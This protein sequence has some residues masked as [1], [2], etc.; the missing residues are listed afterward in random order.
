MWLNVCWFVQMHSENY[1]L[2]CTQMGTAETS[3]Q[4]YS[5]IVCILASVGFAFVAFIRAVPGLRPHGIIAATGFALTATDVI[6]GKHHATSLANV[7]LIMV[8]VIGVTTLAILLPASLLLPT[9]AHDQLRDCLAD[10][11]RDLG[12][13]LSSYI[14]LLLVTD[15]KHSCILPSEMAEENGKQGMADGQTRNLLFMDD[16]EIRD[17]DFRQYVLGTTDPATAKANAVKPNIGGFVTISSVRA[18]LQTCSTLLT[19]V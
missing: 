3:T 7:M 1:M 2:A 8:K 18:R 15:E 12:S 11:V 17:E 13:A 9:L 4:H 6:T 16:S 19:E 5:L 14:S 10:A